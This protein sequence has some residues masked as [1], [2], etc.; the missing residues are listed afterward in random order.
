MRINGKLVNTWTDP[1]RRSRAG[2]VGLQNYN[3]G[4]AVRAADLLTAARVGS[5]VIPTHRDGDALFG[6]SGSDLAALAAVKISR[7]RT[8]RN[9]KTGS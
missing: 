9:F 2:Y 6:L 4:K 7:R 3:D 1:E 8:P 5:P